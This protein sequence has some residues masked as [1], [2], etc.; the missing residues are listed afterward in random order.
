VLMAFETYRRTFHYIAEAGLPA[1]DVERILHHNAQ[2][3]LGL[4]H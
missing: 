2:I 1:D 3:A 4:P